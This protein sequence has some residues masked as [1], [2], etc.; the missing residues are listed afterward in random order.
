MRSFLKTT[1]KLVLW[2]GGIVLVFAAVMRIF[3]VDVAVV[4]H[5]AMAPTMEAGDTILIWRN[6]VPDAMGDITICPHPA[7]PSQLV[8]GRVVG[9]PG[10]TIQPNRFGALEIAG[11]VPDVDWQGTETFTD[12]LEDRTDDYKRGLEKLG[13]VE[14][15]IYVREGAEFRMSPV[16]V[17]EGDVFLL[18]D[19]RTHVG[20]D[21]RYFGT[22][23][24][25]TCQGT[26]F[27]RLSPPSDSPNDIGT[28]YLDIID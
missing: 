2:A 7:Q 21:S 28:S 5:N 15:W 19:N 8:M 1:G 22:V 27:M 10:M 3:F 23:D 9:K 6:G 11:S 17:G 25:E 16:T 4:G 26:V 13:N 20:Q 14:H 24:P 12:T 18:G